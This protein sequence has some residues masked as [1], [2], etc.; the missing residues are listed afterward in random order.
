MGEVCGSSAT[1]SE[2]SKVKLI[3]RITC[4]YLSH[5]YHMIIFRKNT[6]NHC[7]KKKLSFI[8]V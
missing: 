6:L 5:N 8:S 2:A 1:A 4:N 7:E 3:Y